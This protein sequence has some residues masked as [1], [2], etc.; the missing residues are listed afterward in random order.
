MQEV[1]LKTTSCRGR[2]IRKSKNSFP[3]KGRGSV[4]PMKKGAGGEYILIRPPFPIG[5]GSCEKHSSLFLQFYLFPS[6][7]LR[8][9]KSF[10]MLCFAS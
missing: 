5:E 8:K 9:G 1:V 3:A 10:L 2:G 4:S 6:L 7:I